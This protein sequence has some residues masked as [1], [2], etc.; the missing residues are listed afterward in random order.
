MYL[1]DEFYVNAEL[2]LPEA[3]E[4]EGFP[5]L[6]NGVGLIASMDEE[7]D[8]ALTM[9]KKK[10]TDRKVS[11]ATGEASYRF[12]CAATKKIEEKTGVQISVYPVKNNFFGGKVT[13][14]G[15][16]CGCDLQ[17]TLLDNKISGDVLICSSMLKC[18]EDIFLD[19]MTVPEIEENTGV[20]LIPTDNDGYIFVENIIGEELVF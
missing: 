3:D 20:T 10:Y 9:I 16:I 12:I 2:P 13:V 19:D 15:L 6:E 14:T 7:I 8:H 17:K 18:D 4:Y 1:S 5:Q 11:V